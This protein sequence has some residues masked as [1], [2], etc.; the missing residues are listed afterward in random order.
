MPRYTPRSTCI[1]LDHIAI[2]KSTCLPVRLSVYQSVCLSV[3]YISIYLFFCVP[4]CLSIY[5][6]V[7]QSICLSIYLSLYICLFLSVDLVIVVDNRCLLLSPHPPSVCPPFP[8]SHI[9]LSRAPPR[10]P[11]LYN[12]VGVHTRVRWLRVGGGG[13]EHACITYWWLVGT[14]SG[15]LNDRVSQWVSR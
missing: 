8:P 7:G 10:L 6:S 12:K 11:D 4:M 3:I 13:E 15:V 14:S 2:Y 5:Q 1:C 9:I